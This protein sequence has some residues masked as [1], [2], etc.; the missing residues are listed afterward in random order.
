MEQDVSVTA[1]KYGL[2]PDQAAGILSAAREK[3]F[4]VRKGR[5]KPHLD[6]KMLTAWNGM[7][8]CLNLTEL[9]FNFAKLINS[10]AL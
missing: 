8:V 5:P 6:T 7:Y 2:T 10:V 9:N 3:L 1:D 4:N